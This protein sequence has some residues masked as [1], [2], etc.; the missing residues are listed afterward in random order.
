MERLPFAGGTEVERQSVIADE[1]A[2]RGFDAVHVPAIERALMAALETPLDPTGL[3][4]QTLDP[5]ECVRELEFSLP[6]R[7][8][9]GGLLSAQALQRCLAAHA[10][11]SE[12]WGSA[13]AEA[14]GRLDFA[15]FEGFLR[16]FLDLVV[17][18]DERLFVVDYKSN[19]LGSHYGDYER[20]RLG[21]VMESHHYLLQGLL[22]AVAAHRYA[23]AR[24]AG[25]RYATHFGG[26]SYLF[27][28]GALPTA[29]ASGAGVYFF[30]PSEELIDDLSRLLGEEAPS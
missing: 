18:K 1:L 19:H 20:A 30:R 2:R 28:R 4:L 23:K 5:T 6:V 10:G 25:Y 9:G 8:L 24:I 16:G 29:P 22:Y 11:A 15:A 3:R 21:V 14:V 7:D 13:Y 26:V 12:D 17:Y 27:L